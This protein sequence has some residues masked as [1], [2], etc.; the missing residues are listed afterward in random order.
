MVGE[1]KSSECLYN[2]RG[3]REG[4]DVPFDVK[5]KNSRRDRLPCACTTYCIRST[6]GRVAY[7]FNTW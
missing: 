4:I 2:I 6:R 5:K 7:P 3:T 1:T